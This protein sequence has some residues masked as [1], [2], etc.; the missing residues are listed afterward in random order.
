V[1]SWAE[2]PGIAEAVP[3]AATA[4]RGLDALRAEEMEVWKRW[5]QNPTTPDFAWLHDRHKGLIYKAQERNLKTT[6]LPKAAV[7]SDGIRQ[8]ITA[9]QS[10]EPAK[11]ALST[12]LNQ[13]MQHNGRYLQKYQNIG[14]IPEERG[15][16]IGLFQNRLAHLRETLS[17]EPSNAELADDMKASMAEVAELNQSARKLTPAMVGT[18]RR[19]VRRDLNQD[20]PGGQ[21]HLE[22][23]RLLDH[24]IFLHGSLSPEQQLVL[25][26]MHEGFG[27]PVIEDPVAL[28]PVIGLSPQ[29]IRALKKQ[30]GE[31]VRRYYE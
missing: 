12:H 30:I 9:L 6:S 13:I 10:W 18:L 26:H 28:A 24:L 16:M 23:S 22:S 29:K 25:E 17:R 3:P 14:K 20:Q 2:N 21:A 11:G 27:K 5:K 4:Q 19:E 1:D 31:Q 15:R 7:V 8:Y